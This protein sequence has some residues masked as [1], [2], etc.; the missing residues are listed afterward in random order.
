ME[1]KTKVSY[2]DDLVDIFDYLDHD[3]SEE[4]HYINKNC[5]IF[6]DNNNRIKIQNTINPKS[7][8]SKDL[9]YLMSFNKKG[10]N[11]SIFQKQNLIDK[12]NSIFFTLRNYISSE[13]NSVNLK[14][15]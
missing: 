2:C 11:C 7:I 3:Y 13:K 1:L 12:N 5:D 4:N 14:I 9:E 8:D 10:E 6:I 15:Q